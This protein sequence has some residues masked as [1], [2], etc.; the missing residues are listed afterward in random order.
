MTSWLPQPSALLIVDVSNI[1]V[2]IIY[3]RSKSQ[4]IMR[5][6]WEL[7]DLLEVVMS[8][9]RDT[10]SR[11]LTT[12]FPRVKRD[13]WNSIET[14][15]LLKVS[16]KSFLMQVG[17][18]SFVNKTKPHTLSF[19]GLS[20]EE[21]KRHK[22]NMSDFISNTSVFPFWVWSNFFYANF[23]YTFFGDTGFFKL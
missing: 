14:A 22:I 17:S 7:A 16:C 18:F 20:K 23:A 3:C 6:E 11:R 4:G 19:W 8:E 1:S 12:N 5:I 21:F 9:L 13:C 2:V 15:P 10:D